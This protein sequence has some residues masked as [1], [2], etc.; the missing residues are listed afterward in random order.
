[1]APSSPRAGTDVEGITV[2]SNGSPLKLSIAC[3]SDVEVDA[4][5]LDKLVAIMARGLERMVTGKGCNRSGADLRTE[6]DF[7]ADESVTTQD[8]TK[9]H[10]EHR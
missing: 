6:V 5:R 1:M 4:G 3:R 7:F 9:P 2:S 8:R 10:E